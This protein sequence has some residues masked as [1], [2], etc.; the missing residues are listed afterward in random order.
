MEI[1]AAI[2]VI[3]KLL[4]SVLGALALFLGSGLIG[5]LN[6]MNIG[7]AI[8]AFFGFYIIKKSVSDIKIKLDWMF[9]K[10]TLHSALPIALTMVFATIYFKI[11]IV[12]LSLF[13]VSNS[14]IGYYSAAVKLIEILNVI[15]SII[16]M[17][18]FPILANLYEK[19]YQSSYQC[20]KK[21]LGY[22]C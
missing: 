5:L 13:H 3:N 22:S 16:V 10:K 4:I 1:G 18:L 19:Q 21:H 8:S 14:E 12:M 17:G 2:K 9:I 15:P 20:S 11:D 7:S 6:W